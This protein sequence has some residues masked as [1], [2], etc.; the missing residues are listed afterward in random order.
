MCDITAL[1]HA[2]RNR[3][4]HPKEGENLD[5]VSDSLRG[6]AMSESSTN[7]ILLYP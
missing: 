1:M 2:I 4:K 6:S 7:R 5:R 3:A